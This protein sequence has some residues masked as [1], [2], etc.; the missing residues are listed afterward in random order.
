M[1]SHRDVQVCRT[2]GYEKKLRF[3]PV[4]AQKSK[5][6]RT[7]IDILVHVLSDRVLLAID[8]SV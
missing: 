6:Y 1:S 2:R 7:H 3:Y 5:N 8:D 4:D